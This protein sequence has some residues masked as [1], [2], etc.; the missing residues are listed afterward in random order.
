M[1]LYTSHKPLLGKDMKA[2]LHTRYRYE[3][4][5]YVIELSGKGMKILQ[6]SQTMSRTGN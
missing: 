5:T 1:M 4:F 6:M 3:V 2:I